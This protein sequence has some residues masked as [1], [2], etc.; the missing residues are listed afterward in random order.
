M[1]LE[2]GGVNGVFFLTFLGLLS[3]I[4]TFIKEIALYL[5]IHGPNFNANNKL[6]FFLG[7]TVKRSY[8]S[9]IDSRWA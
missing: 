8:L 1:L 7:E 5:Q 3:D 4:L 9:G 2:V 6:V